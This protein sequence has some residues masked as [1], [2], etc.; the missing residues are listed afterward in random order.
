MSS[1]FYPDPS[2]PVPFIHVVPAG[3]HLYVFYHSLDD[4]FLR[5]G[6]FPFVVSQVYVE[7]RCLN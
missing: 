7:S 3:I 5:V 1:K 2:F 6:M 4:D